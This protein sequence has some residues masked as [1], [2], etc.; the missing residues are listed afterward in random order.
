MATKTSKQSFPRVS[1]NRYSKPVFFFH[2]E[3]I[4]PIDYYIRKTYPFLCLVLFFQ[5]HHWTT[6]TLSS[7]LTDSVIIHSKLN[8]NFERILLFIVSES[9]GFTPSRC[10]SDESRDICIYY[11]TTYGTCRY[12][13][14]FRRLGHPRPP[15]LRSSSYI[16]KCSIED[17]FSLIRTPKFVRVLWYFLYGHS[18]FS[19]LQMENILWP[20][21]LLLAVT[22]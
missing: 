21:I 14:Q 7:Y 9:R 16:S 17:L 13:S 8:L 10:W 20:R 1:L 5:Q 6:S 12:S 22:L 2:Y 18:L 3:C 19:S 4:S 11:G 15:L